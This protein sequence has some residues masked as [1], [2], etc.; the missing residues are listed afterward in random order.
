MGGQPAKDNDVAQ[1]VQRT[2]FVAGLQARVLEA[3]AEVEVVRRVVDVDGEPG[4]CAAGLAQRPQ[5]RATRCAPRPRPRQAAPP[6]PGRSS[7]R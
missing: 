4:L 6:R 7:R 5:R 2:H 1:V 3:E